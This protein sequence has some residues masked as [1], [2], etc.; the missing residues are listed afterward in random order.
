MLLKKFIKIAALFSN[1]KN[2]IS[3]SHH[4]E[5]FVTQEKKFKDFF[6]SLLLV[7]HTTIANQFNY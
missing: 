1:K 6:E 4:I 7:S 2:F 3:N 5:V